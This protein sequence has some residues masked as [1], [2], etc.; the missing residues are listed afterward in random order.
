MET[1]RH[2]SSRTLGRGRLARGTEQISECRMVCRA[3]WRS[4]LCGV[5]AQTSCQTRAG[6]RGPPVC[7]LKTG[8]GRALADQQTTSRALGGEAG[9][10][11]SGFYGAIH[12]GSSLISGTH[13]EPD[14][15][16]HTVTVCVARSGS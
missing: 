9:L 13:T 8:G 4:P 16:T 7:E 6:E 3:P 10:A 2:A 11:K 12:D 1:R 14:L 15:A 5:A